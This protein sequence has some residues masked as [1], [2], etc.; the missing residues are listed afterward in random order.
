MQQVNGKVY[1]PLLLLAA[2]TVPLQGLPNFL[3]Y[4]LPR[5][6]TLRT[7]QGRERI[8]HEI[9]SRL[10]R[11]TSGGKEPGASSGHSDVVDFTPQSELLY[12][13]IEA[14]DALV[15]GSDNQDSCED[16]PTLIKDLGTDMNELEAKS[17]SP[18]RMEDPA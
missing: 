3:V 13:E 5:L 7:P 12:P 9:A 4:L 16:L 17:S 6:K 8:V 2:L 15:E 14:I 1:F 11:L 10:S 18:N